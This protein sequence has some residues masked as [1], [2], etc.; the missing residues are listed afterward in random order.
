M[1]AVSD[2][3]SKKYSPLDDYDQMVAAATQTSL[4]ILET[5]KH[6]LDKQSTN[7]MARPLMQFLVESSVDTLE[8]G[9]YIT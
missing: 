1:P 4:T 8:D 6:G 5:E 7:D 9:K 2:P 3:F